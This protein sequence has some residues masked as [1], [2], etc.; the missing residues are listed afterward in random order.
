MSNR[1]S[2][3]LLKTFK[4]IL[5]WWKHS[6]SMLKC[7]QIVNRGS[8]SVTCMSTPWVCD[9]SCVATTYMTHI[10]A[11][12]SFSHFPLSP[13]TL[14]A[15]P[16][17]PRGL[18]CMRLFIMRPSQ[19]RSQSLTWLHLLTI[20]TFLWRFSFVLPVFNIPLLLLSFNFMVI[21]SSQSSCTT[22]SLLITACLSCDCLQIQ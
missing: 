19:G 2:H 13:E 20:S 22:C 12:I 11:Q 4:S 16:P 5:S 1:K 10:I 18:S 8:F 21:S 9:P 14:L 17:L 6:A 15:P 7:W 3:P